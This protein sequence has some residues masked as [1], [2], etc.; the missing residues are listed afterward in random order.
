[1]K[2][3]IMQPYFFPYLGYFQLIRSVDKFILF[4]KI[5]HIK[6]GW[7]N[8]NRLLVK[9]QGF[10]LCPVP[11]IKP[12]ILKKISE[13][14]IDDSKPWRTKLRKHLQIHYSKAPMFREVY[15]F[16]NRLIDYQTNSLYELNAHIITSVCEYLGIQTLICQDNTTYQHIE[17]KLKDA[18]YLDQYPGL[19]RKNVRV[20]EICRYEGACEFHN[21]IG[22]MQLYSGKVFSEYGI[23]IKFIKTDQ[24]IYKQF[25]NEF[26][27]NL[28]II[29]VMMFND[30][31][32]IAAMLEQYALV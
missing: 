32:R 12:S 14:E 31:S 21:A 27:A 22:G 2:L 18:G 6:K 4:G 10:V 9:N 13:L 30:T 19:D 29:D 3:A 23:S 11:L 20:I 1:M 17:E 26:I 24:V 5:N 7:V 28:S 25:D 16:L 8:R 15:P